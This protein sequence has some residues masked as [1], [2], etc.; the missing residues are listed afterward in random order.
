M[1]SAPGQRRR[2]LAMQ[3]RG[4]GQRRVMVM[5]SARAQQVVEVDQLG[6]RALG[7]SCR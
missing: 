1:I 2:R 4:L 5:K 7:A 3:V 6:A